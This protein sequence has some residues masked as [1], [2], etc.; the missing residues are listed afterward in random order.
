MTDITDPATRAWLDQEDRRTAEMIRRRGVY[1][2][3]VG[4]AECE[5]CSPR[6]RADRRR[7]K[8]ETSAPFAY[9]VGLFG[10]GHPELAVVGLSARDAATVLNYLAACVRM[11]RELVP[12][13]VIDS[14]EPGQ[15]F[16]V[17][18][19]PNPGQIAF[20]ANRHYQRPDAFSVELLQLTWSDSEGR[21]P[22]EPGCSI[23][24]R[25]QPRPGRWRA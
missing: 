11:G 9:T 25:V 13:E 22:G 24:T 6:N 19:V 1:I 23:P 20:A 4:G 8:R 18:V 15:R 3:Y 14:L 10:L 16:L 5:C 21:F 2:Q 7:A 17:E 12:G